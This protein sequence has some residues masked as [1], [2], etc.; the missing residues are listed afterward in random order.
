MAPATCHVGECLA[1]WM[2]LDTV[3]FSFFLVTLESAH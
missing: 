3:L 1:S 2:N